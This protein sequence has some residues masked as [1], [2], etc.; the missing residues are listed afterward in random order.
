MS[1][2]KKKIIST[3]I[4]LVSLFAILLGSMEDKGGNGDTRRIL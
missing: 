1:N 4:L 2:K 3:S